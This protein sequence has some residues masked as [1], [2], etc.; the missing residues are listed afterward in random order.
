MEYKFENFEDLTTIEISKKHGKLDQV[1]FNDDDV[2]CND[3]RPA[4]S[5]MLDYDLKNNSDVWAGFQIDLKQA[6]YLRNALNSFIEINKTEGLGTGYTDS[7]YEY[8]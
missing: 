3:N 5:F 8:K 4:F 1:S 7:G 6:I 2:M